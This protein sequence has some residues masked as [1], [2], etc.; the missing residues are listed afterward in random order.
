MVGAAETLFEEHLGGG[1]PTIQKLPEQGRQ[2]SLH[3]E[4][5]SHP[6]A[7]RGANEDGPEAPVGGP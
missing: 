6:S 3:L 4:F 1:W 7:S 5:K 2:E